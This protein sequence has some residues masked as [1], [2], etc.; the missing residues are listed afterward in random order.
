MH[1]G[2]VEEV[3]DYIKGHKTLTGFFPPWS[4]L[5]HRQWQARWGVADVNGIENGELCLSINRDFRHASIVCTFRQ[6]LIYRLC[7]A[8]K[9]ECK[10]NH[11]T[12]WKQNL[13]H[14]VCGPHVH[15]W[16]E[17]RHYVLQNGFGEMPVR[18]NIEGLVETLSD[19]LGWA[20]QDLNI[21]VDPGQRDFSYPA[22]ELV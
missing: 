2:D 6:R 15:G 16:P 9:T 3:D 21:Q 17:N 7:I 4:P 11:H 10:M 12:A 22:R 18:R 14:E 5:F 13:P 8:P 1:E 19:A 20:A